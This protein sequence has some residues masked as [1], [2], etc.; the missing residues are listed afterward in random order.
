VQQELKGLLTGLVFCM[1]LP[2]LAF[3]ILPGA[4]E[5]SEVTVMG[6]SMRIQRYMKLID[7]KN[8]AFERY[9]DKADRYWFKAPD[10]YSY[11]LS[12]SDMKKAVSRIK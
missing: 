3:A 12:D 4:G 6:E 7:D 5:S 8:W 2:T 10:G 9:D 11:A 1:G